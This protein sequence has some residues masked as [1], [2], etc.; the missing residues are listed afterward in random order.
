MNVIQINYLEV[1]N[2]LYNN[3][4]V[5]YPFH[6]ILID[7]EGPDEIAK[8]LVKRIDPEIIDVYM[9]TELGQGMLIGMVMI[10]YLRELIN[11]G[12]FSEKDEDDEE[13]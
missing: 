4:K 11:S 13:T 3:F 9:E 5:A 12:R 6:N 8:V 7:G 10:F 2:I 1:G